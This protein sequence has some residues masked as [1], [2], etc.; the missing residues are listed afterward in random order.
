MCEYETQSV[1]ACV[2]VCE[3]DCVCERARVYE[4]SVCNCV[5][6][7]QGGGELQQCIG[8]QDTHKDGGGCGQ[9]SNT[10]IHS[11]RD[12]YIHTRTLTDTH[13]HIH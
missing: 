5:K 11:H 13:A 12:P 9:R 10:H 6:T 3:R 1:C 2:C 7:R 4:C 8:Q